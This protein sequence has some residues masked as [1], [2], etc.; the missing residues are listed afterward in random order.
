MKRPI[1]NNLEKVPRY[2]IQQLKEKRCR[3]YISNE[4]TSIC[5]MCLDDAC[6]DIEDRNITRDEVIE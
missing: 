4:F 2:T 5:Q 6:Q 1:H 3:E